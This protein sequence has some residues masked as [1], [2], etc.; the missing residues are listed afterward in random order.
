MIGDYLH[1]K[2]RLVPISQI[3]KPSKSRKA[4]GFIDFLK[5]LPVHLLPVDLLPV[6]LL[7]VHLLPVHLLP[8]ATG[9]KK[10][11]SF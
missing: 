9:K 10:V 2:Y 5:L 8:V 1:P 6:H 3:H 11:D 4:K 7:P